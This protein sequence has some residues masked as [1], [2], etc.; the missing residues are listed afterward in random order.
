MS[1]DLQITEHEDGRITISGSDKMMHVIVNAARRDLMAN[2]MA[3][4]A[5]APYKRFFNKAAQVLAEQSACIPK[6]VT[7]NLGPAY[8]QLTDGVEETE[9]VD[10]HSGEVF[11]SHDA[12][13]ESRGAYT[14]RMTEEF[15][16]AQFEPP[17]GDLDDLL[18]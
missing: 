12:Y 9:F 1:L 5:G 14:Q 16:A 3:L 13:L 8:L 2:G 17:A 4:G 11:P 10:P 15:T 18:G 7:M 6:F